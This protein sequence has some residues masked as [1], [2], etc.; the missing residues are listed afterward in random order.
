MREG[1]GVGVRE[2]KGVGARVRDLRERVRALRDMASRGEWIPLVNVKGRLPWRL[3][4]VAKEIINRRVVG[5]CYPHDTPT[6]S[7][8]ADSFI[9]K[10]GCWRAASK[11]QAFLVILVTVLRGYVKTFRT[12]LRFLVLGLR[13][14]EG[15]TYSV[16]ELDARGLN[17]GAKVLSE[18]DIERARMLILEG[19]AMIE[20]SVA[21]CC[22]IPAFHCLCHYGDGASI[23][24]LLRLFWM[25][26]FG[27][28][29]VCGESQ[30]CLLILII[31]IVNLTIVCN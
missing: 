17:R 18:E 9:R 12:G 20:G 7:V 21:V 11:L 24:G 8:G 31:E 27:T 25:M 16:N 15:Q 29:T 26:A 19:M 14:L 1:K 4:S 28:S 13:I 10:A 6:C 30:E 5:I 22:L 3:T 2:G 23:L